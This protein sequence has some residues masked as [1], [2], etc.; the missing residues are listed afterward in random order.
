MDYFDAVFQSRL[1]TGSAL[2]SELWSLATI[3]SDAVLDRTPTSDRGLPIAPQRSLISVN[4]SPGSLW[5]GVES[6]AKPTFKQKE[7]REVLLVRAEFELFPEGTEVTWER[8]P[9]SVR[10][11]VHTPGSVGLGNWRSMAFNLLAAY[12]LSTCSRTRMF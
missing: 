8:P 4:V 7:D 3:A 2:L 6:S 11:A 5:Q 12:N 1:E 9:P 10:C